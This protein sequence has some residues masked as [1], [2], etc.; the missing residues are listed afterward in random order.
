MVNLN[1]LKNLIFLDSTNLVSNSNSNYYTNSNSNDTSYNNNSVD[2]K[3][4]KDNF[5]S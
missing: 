4:S 2:E 3:V 5:K 1:N